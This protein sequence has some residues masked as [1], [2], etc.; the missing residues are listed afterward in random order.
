MIFNAYRL[1]IFIFHVG[2]MGMFFSG[3]KFRDNNN[4]GDLQEAIHI[5]NGVLYIYSFKYFMACVNM[6]YPFL[7]IFN[8]CWIDDYRYLDSALRA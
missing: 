2:F 4:G 5:S 3:N 8:A 6:V 7:L 1:F